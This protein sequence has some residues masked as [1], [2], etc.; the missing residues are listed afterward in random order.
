ME[1]QKKLC[2][3]FKGISISSGSLPYMLLISLH[4]ICSRSEEKRNLGITK[5]KFV[6]TSSM[7]V[8]MEKVIQFLRTIQILPRPHPSMPKMKR[9]FLKNLDWRDSPV[10][11]IRGEIV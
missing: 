6:K 5:R 11:C 9:L 3:F 1:N 2:P 4:S 10:Q 8:L 7:E